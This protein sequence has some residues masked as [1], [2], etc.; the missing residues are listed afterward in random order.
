[1]KE[2]FT[3][4]LKLG[5]VCAGV[6]WQSTHPDTFSVPSWIFVRAL[7]VTGITA[8]INTACWSMAI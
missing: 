3:M 5:T 6:Q 2:I 7:S 8:F 1:M 4:R